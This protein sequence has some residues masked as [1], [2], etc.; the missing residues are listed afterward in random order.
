MSTKTFKKTTLL[1]TVLSIIVSSTLNLPPDYSPIPGCLTYQRGRCQTCYLS[2]PDDE[3]GNC[4]P[5]ANPLSS[6]CLVYSAFTNGCVLCKQGYYIQLGTNPHCRPVKTPIKDCYAAQSGFPAVNR[7]VCTSCEKGYPM[8][9]NPT[10]CVN[11]TE[12]DR[13]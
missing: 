6:K 9:L 2:K 12:S 3:T 5:L 7:V 8:K 10:K 13:L 11:Y 4:R 1:L